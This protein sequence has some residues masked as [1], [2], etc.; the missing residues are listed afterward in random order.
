MA[1]ITMDRDDKKIT[2]IEFFI[3]K[4]V[5][6]KIFWIFFCSFGFFFPIV[7]SLYRELPPDLPVYFQ[8]PNY[9][10]IDE[11]G[12]N[13]GSKD[14][15]G[16]VYVAN[17]IFT[18]C[19]ST[20]PGLTAKMQVIQKRVRGLGQNIGLVSFSVDPENDTP[21]VLFEYA[22]K[23]KAN[24]YVWHF[25]TGEVELLEEVLINGFKVP[26][27]EKTLK[28]GFKM[29][30]Q[31]MDDISLIDIA[32]SEKFVLVDSFGR[33]RGYYSSEKDSINKMMIDIGLLVNR[34]PKIK[35]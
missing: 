16:M 32:H 8:L 12:K 29:Q 6:K 10:F 7:K 31:K 1:T 11:N 27:G 23:H 3:H 28:S 22:R 26:L 35:K 14:L 20:C 19:P 15:H 34:I 33:I 24:P 18:S 30:N 9:D 13:F 2:K 25:L 17:F 4:L 5:K 21:K